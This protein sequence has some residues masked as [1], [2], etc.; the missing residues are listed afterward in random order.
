MDEQHTT[1]LRSAMPFAAALGVEVI[2]A[3]PDGVV[4][5]T[6]WAEDRTTSGGAIHGGYLMAVADSVAA[7]LAFLNLPQGATT[8]TIESKT[9]FLRAVRSG[10]VTF[11]A[12]PVHIGSRTIVVQTD[13][14]GDNGELVSR[15]TQTQAVITPESASAAR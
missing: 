14:I 2:A 10:T 8:A 1:M 7:L 5:A 3:A 12:T 11:N 13:A 4:A 9:N 6:A 15:T